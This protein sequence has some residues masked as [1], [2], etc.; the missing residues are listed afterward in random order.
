M[1]ITDENHGRSADVP[2]SPKTPKTTDASA[3]AAP[4]KV[5]AR[6]PGKSVS[7]SKTAKAGRVSADA[8]KLDDKK[9]AAGA[10]AA[11][12]EDEDIEGA[13]GEAEVDEA[14]PASR[15]SPCSSIS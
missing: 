5:R 14:E 11:D 7:K 4:P 12:T 2:R 1:P 3:P 9:A 10:A 13:N 8:T 6:A 15:R